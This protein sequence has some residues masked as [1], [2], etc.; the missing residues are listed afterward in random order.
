MASTINASNSGFGGIVS[1]GDSSGQLQLQTANTTALTLD[2]SQNATFAGKVTS[3]GALTL[4]SNGSTTAVTI[5]TSQNVG[6]GT[7]SPGAK[8]DVYN[9]SIN[10]SYSPN[11]PS[12]WRVAQ[13]R[14]DQTSTTNS[15]AGIAF[16]GKSDT[17]PAGIVAI[18]SNT[19]GGIVGLGFLTVNSNITSES[20]RL[21][22]GGS[23]LIGPSSSAATYPYNTVNAVN[24]KRQ[25]TSG[26]AQAVFNFSKSTSSGSAARSSFMGTLYVA[27]SGRTSGGTTSAYGFSAAVNIAST[28]GSTISASFGSIAT[29]NAVSSG[30]TVSCAVSLTSASATSANLSVTITQTAGTLQDNEITVTLIGANSSTD[31]TSFFTVTPA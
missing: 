24:Y 18:N 5:D 1:T 2:T 8:L 16:V 26:T 27:F 12:T 29:F 22:S 6:I 13:V 19:T 25:L 20:M 31:S 23:L 10:A 9:P 28:A 3:A 7:T 21:D 4:A 14:N 11:T 15:A 30:L 17:Q